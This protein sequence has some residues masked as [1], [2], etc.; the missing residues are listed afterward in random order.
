LKTTYVGRVGPVRVSA[1]EGSGRVD[2]Y[3]R[4]GESRLD[5]EEA[6]ALTTVLIKARRRAR[7]KEER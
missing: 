5:S 4:G 7:P 1:L 3:L 6:A 2:V